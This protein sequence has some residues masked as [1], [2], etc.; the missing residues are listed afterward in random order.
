MSHGLSQSLVLFLS[1]LSFSGE[2]EVVV[3]YVPCLI[4]AQRWRNSKIHNAQFVTLKKIISVRGR[5]AA[6][7]G[8]LPL[9]QNGEMRA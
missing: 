9:G 7:K 4:H 1:S 3:R 5:R 6:L 2:L 8:A